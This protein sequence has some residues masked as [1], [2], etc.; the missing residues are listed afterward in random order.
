MTLLRPF[1]AA[2]RHAVRRARAP[3]PTRSVR[4]ILRGQAST[5]GE[6]G[7]S[8]DLDVVRAVLALG[9]TYDAAGLEIVM[10][11]AQ[12]MG[13]GW[14]VSAICAPMRC[15]PVGRS[16]RLAA[17]RGRSA[18]ALQVNHDKEV[19][20][21]IWLSVETFRRCFRGRSDWRRASAKKR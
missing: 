10:D 9:W 17:R 7:K 19:V 2:W 14:G 5:F 4:L 12:T 1:A 13:S 20:A 11:D 16:R 21:P 15:V 8:E 6:A 3:I 18:L